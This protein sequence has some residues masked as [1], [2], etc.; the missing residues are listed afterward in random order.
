MLEKLL[1]LGSFGT[2]M[3]HLVR[4]QTILFVSL[5]GLGLP[6]VVQCVTPTFLKCWVSIVLTLVS[7]F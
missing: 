4:H 7:H 2:I 6:L 5:G 1:V 3:G